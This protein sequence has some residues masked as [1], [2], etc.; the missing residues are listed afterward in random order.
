MNINRMDGR[1]KKKNRCKE[2]INN[3]IRNCLLR[4]FQDWQWAESL[5]PPEAFCK[6]GW[7]RRS[8]SWVVNWCCC[9]KKP[10]ASLHKWCKRSAWGC[11]VKWRHGGRR[12]TRFVAWK[13]SS[14]ELS[15][16]V[17]FSFHWRRFCARQRGRSLQSLQIRVH[18]ANF[19][20]LGIHAGVY[21]VYK[22]W[23]RL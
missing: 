17:D 15:T 1:S 21:K 11:Y 7:M 19:A 9:E 16:L 18:S 12:W 23:A 20:D 3:N 13:A 4:I 8:M 22:N 10:N 5:H 14:S 6:G 2:Q